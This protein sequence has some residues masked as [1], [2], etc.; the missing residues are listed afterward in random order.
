MVLFMVSGVPSQCLLL[1]WDEG[2]AMTS[3]AVTLQC[4]TNAFRGSAANRV[5]F[6]IPTS[7]HA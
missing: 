3:G 1:A 6:P 7:Q 4:D 2:W 5:I